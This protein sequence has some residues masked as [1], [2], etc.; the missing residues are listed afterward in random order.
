MRRI[1]AA[2]AFARSWILRSAV[3]RAVMSYAHRTP[4]LEM[5]PLAKPMSAAPA[6]CCLHGR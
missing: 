6:P 3:Q 5:T 2:L 4:S 1:R